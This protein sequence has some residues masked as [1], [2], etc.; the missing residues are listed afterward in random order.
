MKKITFAIFFLAL[1][2]ITIFS[3]TKE[4]AKLLGP[5]DAQ[6]IAWSQ[7]TSGRF[8]YQS[9]S[10]AILAPMGGSPHG[11]FKLRFNSIAKNA[12]GSDGKLPSGSTFP[13]SSLLVKVMYTGSTINGYATIFKLNGAWSWGEYSAAGQVYQSVSADA[14]FCLSCHNG[15]NNRDQVL[16]FFYH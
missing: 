14:S 8:Y 2:L 16:T 6:M 5:N 12:L 1:T 15:A 11:N 9:D 13:D 3:C 10:S 7:Q 4:K